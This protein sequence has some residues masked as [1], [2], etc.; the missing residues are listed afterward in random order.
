MNNNQLVIGENLR[1]IREQLKITQEEVGSKL[2]IGRDAIIR[3]EKGIRKVSIEELAGFSKIYGVSAEDIISGNFNIGKDDIKGIILAG[4]S[5]TRLYPITEGTSKQLIPVYDKPMI[6]YPLSVLMEA[7]IRD[8]LVITTPIVADLIDSSK[9]KAYEDQVKFIIDA[10]KNY[11][12]QYSNEI[13]IDPY[14]VNVD[15]L[16]NKGFI[17]QEELKNP[18]TKKKMD[19]CVKIEYNETFND[20]DYTYGNCE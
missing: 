7:G 18:K 20:Y 13:T 4:G 17:D 2:G 3:I 8:I 10:A 5:G 9:Q 1:K 11:S 19:G 6:Y 14:Y 15:T 12:V 16:I